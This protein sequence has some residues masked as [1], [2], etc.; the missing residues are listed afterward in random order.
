MLGMGL[1]LSFQD[2]RDFLKQPKAIGLGVVAQFLKG[3]TE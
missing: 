3:P 1:T 2:F